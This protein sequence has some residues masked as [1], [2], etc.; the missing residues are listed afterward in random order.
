MI[1]SIK[2]SVFIYYGHIKNA[3]IFAERLK[4]G[5]RTSSCGCGELVE[6][7]SWWTVYLKILDSGS[8]TEDIKS[9]ES[10]VMSQ[11]ALRTF[12]NSVPN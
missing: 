1:R 8:G 5:V 12:A 2:K 7:V 11:E 6:S 10:E 3:E 4:L 9:S